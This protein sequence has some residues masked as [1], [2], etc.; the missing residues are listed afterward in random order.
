MQ[1]H[2]WT[3]QFTVR[4]YETDANGTL[5][6][7]SLCDFLQRM[8]HVIVRSDDRGETA[9]VRTEWRAS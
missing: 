3:E 8:S 2:L 4:I 1:D 5:A 9:C 6:V 7:R